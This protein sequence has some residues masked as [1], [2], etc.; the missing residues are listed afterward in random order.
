MTDRFDILI[1]GGRVVDPANRVDQ[2][3]DVGV[4]DG[5]IVAV[6]DDLRGR[7]E[8]TLQAAGHY[9][10]PGLVDLHVHIALP[11]A[12]GAGHAM[13]ARAGVTTALDLSGPAAG[14]LAGAAEGGGAGLS[15]ATLEL[16]K[17]GVQLPPHPSRAEIRRALDRIL[18]AGGLGV[19]LHVDAGWDAEATGTIIDEA[20]RAGVWVASHCGTTTAGSDIE[21]LRETLELAG[22]NRLQIAHVNSYCRG[23][24]ADVAEEAATAIALLRGSPHVF[25]ES[26]LAEINGT[27]GRCVDG[28]PANRRVIRWLEGGGYPG[29]EEGLRRAI[30]DGWA[31][32]PHVCGDDVVL[33]TGE[34]GVAAWEA[35]GTP[36]GVCLPINPGVS[37]LLL[38]ASRNAAGGFDVHA[39]ATDGGCIPRNVTLSMG[40]SMV[41]WGLLRVD[42]LVRKAC[43][44]PARVLGLAAKGHLGVGADADLVVADPV[45]RRPR[46]V[47]AAGAVVA[48]EGLVLGRGTRFISTARGEEAVEAATGPGT[49]IDVRA[50]GLYTGDGLA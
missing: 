40:L 4:A 5:R 44:T 41:E 7:A 43:W 1:R 8:R 21:G 9:V 26:Y 6:G 15:I 50:G 42:D 34:E 16:V 48:H 18:A 30:R 32:V 14:V 46:T 17:P 47:I 39:F 20:N 22:D 33:R 12:P 3:T 25:A 24:V 31:S 27:S 29:T 37:R 28:V 2:V 11:S 23:D 10:L 35:A 45:A 49:V 38:G 13:L 19:K 36:S